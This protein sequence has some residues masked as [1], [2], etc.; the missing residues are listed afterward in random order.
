MTSELPHVYV[1]HPAAAF[2]I[3]RWFTVECDLTTDGGQTRPVEQSLNFP[4]G[5]SILLRWI[6]VLRSSNTKN[7]SGS[8]IIDELNALCTQWH[9]SN[10]IRPEVLKVLADAFAS[11]VRELMNT[12]IPETTRP[13]SRRTSSGPATPPPQEEEPPQHVARRGPTVF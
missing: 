2:I 13:T 7:R 11:T 12:P 3:S 9:V 1:D 6:P 8:S 4:G 5:T 10:P